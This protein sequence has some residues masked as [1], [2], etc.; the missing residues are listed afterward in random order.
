LAGLPKALTPAEVQCLLAAC[1]RRTRTGRRDF[2]ILLTLVRLGVRAGEV[3]QLAL[4]DVD[5][6]A[7]TLTI[8]GKGPQVDS[9]PVPAD[10]GRALASYLRRGRP[11]TATERTLF[12]RS[13]APHRGLSSTGVTQIVFGAA[14][15]AGLRPLHA[16]CL[17]HT[18]ATQLLRAGATLPE[19]G[20]LLRHRRA[21]T[22][23]IYAKVHR[24]ALRTI[25]QPWL[26]GAR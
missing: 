19:I 25:A 22:T 4:D 26:E 24:A 23:A 21:L 9:L 12:V 18:A 5:W 11:T 1:D 13:R 10:V 6:R 7:G 20:R 3:A 15:R 14:A 2:A 8:R 16:H 17:R